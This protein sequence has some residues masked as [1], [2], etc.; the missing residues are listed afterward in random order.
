M[1]SVSFTNVLPLTVPDS[2]E[3]LVTIPPAD[4][5]TIAFVARDK[6]AWDHHEKKG[7]P[8]LTHLVLIHPYGLQHLGSNRTGDIGRPGFTAVA[9]G[10]HPVIVAC[11]RIEKSIRASVLIGRVR[12][13]GLKI[14][15]IS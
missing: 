5:L 13:Q 8:D 14:H 10:S 15:A 4:S 7:D 11:S 2:L 12:G 1:P 9:L 3:N 6:P